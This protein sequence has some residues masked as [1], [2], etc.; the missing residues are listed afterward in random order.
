MG[1]DSTWNES[2]STSLKEIQELKSFMFKEIIMQPE[3]PQD[4]LT[5]QNQAKTLLFIMQLQIV[6]YL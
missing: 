5:F 1:E 6:C 2:P 3:L 4:T